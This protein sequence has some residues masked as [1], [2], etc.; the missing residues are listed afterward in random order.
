MNVNLKLY[1]KIKIKFNEIKNKEPQHFMLGFFIVK[2][3]ISRT[4]NSYISVIFFIMNSIKKIIKI[5]LKY[6][7]YYFLSL[8]FNILYSVFSIFSIT[9]IIPVLS[10]LFQTVEFKQ[11]NSIKITETQ[12][13]SFQYY[14]IYLIDYLNKAIQEYGKL[15]VLFVMCIIVIITFFIRNL[16]R[17]FTQF[18]IVIFRSAI[19]RDLQIKIYKKILKLP[20]IFFTDQKKGDMMTRIF[21]DVIQIDTGIISAILEISKA[22]FILFLTLSYLFYIHTTLT[23]FALL[24]LPIMG[25]IIVFIGKSLKK[26]VRQIQKGFGDLYSIVDETINGI[27]IIKIFNGEKLMFDKFYFLTKKIRNLALLISKKYELASPMSEFLGSATIMTLVYFGGKIIIEKHSIDPED[28]LAFIALFF[29][30]LDPVKTLTHSFAGI[31]KGKISAK[32]Y[33][34]VLN[35]NIDIKEIQ[36]ALPINSI[37]HGITLK[38]VSFSYDGNRKII[39]SIS[40]FIPRGKT[41]AIVGHSGSGKSTFVNLLAR[42]YDV[43]GGEILIDGY[44]IKDLKISDY[45]KLIGIVTQESIL[46]NDTIKNN[47]KFAKLDASEEEIIKA[48]EISNSLRFIKKLP[49]GFDTGM[50][51][52]GGKISGGQ[53]QRISIARAILKNSPIMIFDEATSSLDSENEYC[54]KNAIQKLMKN[55]TIVIIAH[56]FS[57]IQ[58]ADLIVVMENGKIIEKGTHQELLNLHGKYSKIIHLQKIQNSL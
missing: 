47:L 50:G 55:R 25:T 27:K 9:T 21:N 45:L 24:I 41:I 3:I 22:P 34:E 28:F 58:N 23:F 26:E 19:I 7:K 1:Q 51:E 17:Y 54:V 32:R 46:F 12:K 16:F 6:K 48:A 18:F 14:K 36:N 8:F 2:E 44:N 15:D 29:Q 13:N 56:R 30:M 20:I 5:C 52:L 39:D 11:I 35:F 31:A 4:E 37:S 53:K 42:F 43:S 49:Y 10:I 38:N 33:F 40:L 57:T